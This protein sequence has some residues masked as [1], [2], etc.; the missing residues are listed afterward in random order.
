MVVATEMKVSDSWKRFMLFCKKEC[1]HGKIMVDI[2]AGQ[3]TK[4]VVI[5]KTI[6]L[7]KEGDISLGIEETPHAS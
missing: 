5:E 6:R 7:D 1:K 4:I 3:P 2:A